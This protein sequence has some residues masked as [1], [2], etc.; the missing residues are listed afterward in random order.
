MN[1]ALQ[2][3]NTQLCIKTLNDLADQYNREAERMGTTWRN[4]EIADN[5]DYV[6]ARVWC[7]LTE[8]NEDQLS[9]FEVTLSTIAAD[10][11]TPLAAVYV[12][13]IIGDED[14]EQLASDAVAHDIN[15]RLND[16]CEFAQEFIANCRQAGLE[17]HNQPD[18]RV[19]VSGLMPES[20]RWPR[21]VPEAQHVTSVRNSIDSLDLNQLTQAVRNFTADHFEGYGFEGMEWDEVAIELYKS[22]YEAHARCAKVFEA[23]SGHWE[24]LASNGAGADI[25][26]IAAQKLASIEGNVTISQGMMHFEDGST[27]PIADLLP[28]PQLTGQSTSVASASPIVGGH[29]ESASWTAD[30]VHDHALP[31]YVN[32]M[33]LVDSGNIQGQCGADD[34]LEAF[35]AYEWEMKAG[36]NKARFDELLAAGN[37][38][39]MTTEELHEFLD[40]VTPHGDCHI[41][42][43]L[44]D[45]QRAIDGYKAFVRDSDFTTDATK[46]V[47]MS[48]WR[49]DSALPARLQGK[50]GTFQLT[51]NADIE[52]TSPEGHRSTVSL[53]FDAG[54]PRL[55][56]YPPEA[57]NPA[58]ASA[59]EFTATLAILPGKVIVSHPQGASVEMTEGRQPEQTDYFD[60]DRIIEQMRAEEE[61]FQEVNLDAPAPSHQAALKA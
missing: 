20:I 50:A 7:D 53:E 28:T 41:Y 23:A 6:D 42:H 15:R 51:N 17:M 58:L 22:P 14:Q 35:D 47:S 12:G 56:V 18:I 43:T 31:L 16:A 37:E 40:L 61:A 38:G 5:G 54:V 29:Q 39:D 45:S 44:R 21:K 52:I 27:L 55:H 24:Y 30:S 19:E 11:R 34:C 26:K 46:T 32:L 13:L 2:D 8:K 10:S 4:V 36:A 1:N 3:L 49:E 57:Q 60:G 48:D 25:V 33:K 59:D 9:R